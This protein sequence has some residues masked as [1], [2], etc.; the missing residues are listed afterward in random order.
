MLQAKKNSELWLRILTAA[1]LIPLVLALLWLTSPFWFAAITGVIVLLGAW[2]WAQFV[3]LHSEIGRFN[4]T[5]SFA[6]AGL[7]GVAYL[8]YWLDTHLYFWLSLSAL[9]SVVMLVTIVQYA[10]SKT[11]WCIGS[12]SSALAG[13]LTLLPTWGL[14]QF[15]H[16]FPD[17][18][19][20][21]L[22]ILLLIWITDSVAYF[23]G[24]AFGKTKLIPSVSPGKTLVGFWAGIIGAFIVALLLGVFVFHLRAINL[25]LWLLFCL[26]TSFFSVVGDLFMSVQKRCHH[27]KDTGQLLPGHGGVLDRLDSLFAATPIF[28]LGA[29]ILVFVR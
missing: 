23:A 7:L 16:S 1:I 25:F 2:E 3:G 22:S 5:L 19:W 13:F 21:V 6:I 18:A 10:Q 12:K 29:T 26:L 8:P 9:W 28:V 15:V 20:M 14:L 24:R 27:L 17:G 11:T 4:F